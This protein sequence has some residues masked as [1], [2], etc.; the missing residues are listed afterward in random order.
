M[1]ETEHADS[2]PSSL[3]EI[4]QGW[5][6]LTLRV[7]QLEAE[8]EALEQ[9]NKTLRVLLERVIEHRHKSH[10]ELVLIITNLVSKLPINDVGAIVARLVEHNTSCGQQ[11]AALSKGTV[12]AAVP[13][14]MILKTLDQT[15]R[16]LLA[17]LKPIIEELIKADTPLE[18]E[19]LRSLTDEPELFFSPRVVRAN[20]CFVKG[21][22][23]RERVLKE[24]GDASLVFF[25]DVT[26]DPKLNPNPKSEEIA[27]AFK[28]DFEP[29]LQANPGILPDK[30]QELSALCRRIQRS[31]SSTDEARRQKNLFLRMSF[32]LDLLHFY[33]NQSTEAPDAIFAQ[34]LPPGFLTPDRAPCF[35]YNPTRLCSQF[36]RPM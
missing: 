36:F 16:D 10:N 14:P 31:K 9:D 28:T 12:D 8:R 18:T 11:L 30:R 29:L 22:L 33:D 4:L 6:E 35:C 7:Q 26:T 15:K 17:A 27:L 24:F 13:Q 23:P 34:R 32:I 20:R 19:M 1:T 3:E 25:N 5:H 21:Y 2:P